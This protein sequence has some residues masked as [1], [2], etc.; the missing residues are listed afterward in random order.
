MCGKIRQKGTELKIK[1]SPDN[2]NWGCISDQYPYFSFR[3]MTQNSD[4]SLKYLDNLD[5]N[6]REKTLRCLYE[7][8]E[9]LSKK[10]WLDWHEK[11]KSIGLD[12][13]SIDQLNFSANSDSNFTKETKAYVF[14]FETYQGNHKGRIIGVKLSPC[15]VLHIIGYD[16]NF[17]AYKHS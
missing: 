14:Q 4:Y 6:N 17:S 15:S 2:K 3:Y 8:F 11:R 12:T 16:F 13:I 10:S 9:E 1:K 7:K 5:K